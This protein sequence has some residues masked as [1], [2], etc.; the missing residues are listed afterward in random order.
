MKKIIVKEGLLREINGKENDMFTIEIEDN[1][2]INILSKSTGKEVFKTE[3]VH[4]LQHF[5]FDLYI[6]EQIDIE[7][8]ERVA[9]ELGICLHYSEGEW[10]YSKDRR[11]HNLEK[12]LIENG[13]WI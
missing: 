7:E 8:L 11:V 5:G 9:E 2:I 13:Y 3:N 12:L 10:L 6:L 1:K 4:D